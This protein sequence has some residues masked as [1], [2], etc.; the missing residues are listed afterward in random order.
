[1]DVKYT[2]LKLKNNDFYGYTCISTDE[3]I[4]KAGSESI[5]LWIVF[6]PKY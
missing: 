3:T 6:E 2:P 1:M 4:V 5:W